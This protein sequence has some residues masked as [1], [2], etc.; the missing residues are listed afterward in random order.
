MFKVTILGFDQAYASAITGALDLFALAGVTWQRMQGQQPSPFFDVQ[1]ASI[2]K[3]PIKCINQLTIQSHIAIEDVTETDLLVI[4][5]IGGE[6][7]KVISNNRALLPHIQKHYLKGADIASNCSGA[8][9]LAEA[10]ILDGQEATTHWGYAELFKS[11]YAKVNLCAEKMITSSNNIYCSGG[12]MAW[13]DLAL[14]LIER[15]CGHDV[16]T[17]TAKAHVIDISRGEQVAYANILTKK[18]HQDPEILT[19]QEW[20]EAHYQQAIAMTELPLLVNL[21]GRTFNRR[22]KK[23]TELNPLEYLQTLRIEAAKKHLE[24]SHDSIERIVSQVGYD[25]LS[26]FTRLF[27][28]HTGL[29]PSQ[30]AKKFKR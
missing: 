6:L 7:S 3:R 30:Y 9:L 12:G 20:L 5:T 13:F 19:V 26:S 4:P 1:L 22:F 29:S 24:T 25:D 2:K 8:F 27:K 16:A 23:A 15:Y 21:T 14:L 11:R 18:Y 17:T 28:K 10:G